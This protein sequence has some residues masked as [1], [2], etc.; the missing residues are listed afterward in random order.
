MSLITVVWS[1]VAALV[2]ASTLVLWHPSLWQIRHPYKAWWMAHTG[3]KIVEDE[4]KREEILRRP[5]PRQHIVGTPLG[6]Y[7]DTLQIGVCSDELVGWR[8]N[9]R[10]SP[11]AAPS[12]QRFNGRQG[13]VLRHRHPRLGLSFCE[14]QLLS[15]SVINIPSNYCTIIRKE[16]PHARTH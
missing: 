7:V 1:V 16:I 3:R 10:V 4:A 6:G 13:V 12:F 8:V 5:V 9:I 11:F 15:D 2:L 14:I